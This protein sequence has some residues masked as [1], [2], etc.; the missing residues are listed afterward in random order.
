M[1]QE[2]LD[3]LLR[4]GTRIINAH[5]LSTVWNAEMIYALEEGE[6]EGPLEMNGLEA[7]LSQRQFFVPPGLQAAG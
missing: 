4:E 7:D 2:A 1:I 3:C 6:H 5:R